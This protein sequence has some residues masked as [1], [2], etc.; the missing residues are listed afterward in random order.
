MCAC[1]LLFMDA[2]RSEL[3]CGRNGRM[4]RLQLKLPSLLLTKLCPSV[5]QPRALNP[6][7][8]DE[9]REASAAA[10]QDYG[11]ETGERRDS[12]ASRGGATDSGGGAAGS[13]CAVRP[14]WLALAGGKLF[15]REKV[16]R[17][18]GGVNNLYCEHLKKSLL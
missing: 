6:P 5:H 4:C 7:V 12:R 8:W 18:F 11:R 15:L 17:S 9:T 16:R 1:G 10:V 3:L 14:V 13:P 2:H